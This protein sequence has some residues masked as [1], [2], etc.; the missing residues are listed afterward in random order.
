MKKLLAAALS[1]TML[2]GAANAVVVAGGET[3]VTVLLDVEQLGVTASAT[4]G[5]EVEFNENGQPVFEF[6]ITGGDLTAPNEGNLTHSGGATFTA[7]GNSITLSN[8][9]FDLTNGDVFADVSTNGGASANLNVFAINIVE[10]ILD[11]GN[12][13]DDTDS[14]LYNFT[15]PASTLAV[16][17]DV[18]GT[19]I[20][21]DG[22]DIFA[23]VAI[24]PEAVPVPAAALLFAPIAAGFVARRRRKA[25]A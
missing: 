21:F 13:I 11:N 9:A 25:A 6:D 2:F 15:I 3:T 7:G 22:G 24:D 12:P 5:A 20:D 19:G 10:P 14:N 23:G 4:D 1:S 18:F 8:F 16:L 17:T